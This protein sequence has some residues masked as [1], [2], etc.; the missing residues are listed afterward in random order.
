MTGAH[1]VGE[2]GEVQLRQSRLGISAGE[3]GI[4]VLARVREGERVA[5]DP[6]LAI[7]ERTSKGETAGPR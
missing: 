4:E 3:A 2:T 5:L 6:A 1:L 7:A